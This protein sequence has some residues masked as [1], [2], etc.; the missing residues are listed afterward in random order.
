RG[1]AAAADVF[2][3]SAQAFHLSLPP[4]KLLRNAE[5]VGRVRL[6]E[7]EVVDAASRFPSGKAVREVTLEARRGLVAFGRRLS[8]QLHYNIGDRIGHALPTGGRRHGPASDVAM[9]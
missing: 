3:V 2:E 1:F 5:T 4:V 7:I 6:A 8:E 9:H